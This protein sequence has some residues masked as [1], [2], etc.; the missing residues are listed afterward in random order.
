MQT[1]AEAPYE[2]IVLADAIESPA[3][4]WQ[5]RWEATLAALSEAS[6]PDADDVS[7]THHTAAAVVPNEFWTDM[8]RPVVL[9]PTTERVVFADNSAP[10]MTGR[11][12]WSLYL[13]TPMSAHLRVR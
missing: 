6:H 1:V 3:E 2:R 7:P 13:R 8:L 10:K 4:P 5:W 11:R 9:T 12:H